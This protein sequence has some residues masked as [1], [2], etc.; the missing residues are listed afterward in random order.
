VSAA[1][2]ALGVSFPVASDP[3]WTLVKRW[4]L[5]KT[6]GRWTSFTYILDRRGQVRHVHPGGEFHRGGGPDHARCRQDE[7]Q[8]R[9]LIERLLAE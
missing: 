5:D 2:R 7:Q 8:M 4:W 1:A 3:S 9:A 6:P